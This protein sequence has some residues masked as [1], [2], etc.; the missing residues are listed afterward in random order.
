MTFPHRASL[1]AALLALALVGSLLPAASAREV[2]VATFNILQGTG[3]VGSEAYNAT[4]DVLLRIDADVVCFQELYF[5]SIAPWTNMAAELGYPYTAMGGNNPLA[6]SLSLGF[7]SRF[8]FLATNHVASPPGAVELTRFPFRAVVDVPD[9]LH[10]L[11]LWTSHHKSGAAN[12]DKFRRS[13]E[14]LRISQDIAAYLAD[15]PDHLELV[16]TGDMNDDIRDAQSPAAY[17]SQPSGAPGYYVLGPDVS[18]PVPYA[19]FPSDRYADAGLSRVSAF[20]EGTSTPITRP[21]SS[22]QLDYI[23]LSPALM[24]S[25]LGAPQAEVYHSLNDAGGGLPKLGS[26]LPSGTSATASDHLPI[27]VDIQMADFSCVIPTAPFR[28]SGDPGGPFNPSS[29]TFVLTETNAFESAWIVEPDVDWL[30][31]D[32]PSCSLAPFEPLEIAAFLN[33]RADALPPGLHAASIAF[34]N[35]TTGLLETRDVLLTVHDY[36][37][38]SPSNG[39]ASAGLVG[40]P[41]SPS[42]TSYVVTNKSASPIAFSTSASHSWLSISPSSGLLQPGQAATVQVALNANAAALPIGAHSDT[43]VFSNHVTGLTHERPVALSVAGLLCDALDDCSLAW[44]TGGDAPWTFQSAVASDG[45]DAAQSGALAPNQSSWLET[46]VEGPLRIRFDWKTSSRS[47]HFVRFLVDGAQRASLAGETEW[48]REFHDIASGVHTLRWAYATSA[49]A[50]QGSNA[51]WLDQIRFDFLSISPSSSWTAAGLPGGPFLPSSRSYVLTNSGAKSLTWSVSCLADWLDLSPPSGELPPG[52]SSSVVIALNPNAASKP[53]GSYPSQ[54][55]FSNALSG[56]AQLRPVALE[57]T[58]SLCDALDDC[59]LSWSSGGDAPWFNQTNR[60]FDAS[61]AAQAGSL[62]TNQQ[63]WIETTIQGPARVTFQWRVSSLS[64]A[65]LRFLLDGSPRA[66]ISGTP[67]SWA[68]RLVDIPSG[69]H[70]LR[71]VYVTSNLPPSYENT[72]WLD[73]IVVDPLSVSP[74]TDWHASGLPGGPF[75][76]ASRTYTLTNS[77][78]A[79]ASWTAS[80]STNWLSLSP[81]AGSLAP[82]EAASVTAS[83]VSASAALLPLG[84]HPASLVFSNLA[85]GLTSSIPAFLDTRGSLCDSTEACF[86]DWS[87]GGVLPWFPQTSTSFDGV[88]A[89]QSGALSSNQQSWI[90]AL[91][92]GPVQLHFQWR[93]SSRTNTHLLSFLIDGSTRATLS[94]ATDWSAR[95]FEIPPGVHTARWA[96]A[97]SSTAPSNA[98]AAW[99]DQVQLERFA[100]TPTNGWTAYGLP[101]GPFSPPSQ[102][103][104]LTNAGAESLAWSASSNQPWLSLS[105]SSGSLAPGEGAA[106]ELSFNTNAAAFPVGTR[107]AIATFSNLL[108]GTCLQRAVSLVVRDHLVVSPNSSSH[109][110]FV[111]LPSSPGFQTFSLSN[112]GPDEIEW[113]LVGATNWLSPQTSSGALAPGASAQVLVSLNED[114]HSLPTG[115]NT[116][117]FTFSNLTTHLNQYI[118]V[119]LNQQHPLQ[120][121]PASWFAVGPVGGPFSPPAASFTLTNSCP[122]PQRWSLFCDA[123]WLSLDPPE[124]TLPSRSSQSLSASLNALSLD[125]PMGAHSASLLLLNLDNGTTLTQTVHLAVGINVCDAVEACDLAW[126]LGGDA[127]WLVQTNSTHDGVDALAC[128]PI[129]D[130]QEIWIQTTATGPGTL[131]FWWSVSSEPN[132]DF[133]EF[134]IDGALTNRISGTIAWQPLSYSLPA[135]SHTLRWR[136]AKDV[137]DFAG[138]D[139]AWLDQVA[140]SPASSAMGV[141][142]AWYQRFGLAPPPGASY[143]DLDWLPAA[144][145][146]PLWRQYLSGLDPTQPADAF[147][148]LLIH[149]PPGA[150]PRIEWRGGTNGPS[151]PYVIQGATHLPDGPWTPLGSSPR[152]PGLNVWTNPAPADPSRFFRIQAPP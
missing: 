54:L 55:V 89:A 138:A 56:L 79:A 135:G 103:Y 5:S 96:Y 120:L 81:P 132:Y 44:S 28:P 61:D 147:R 29:Q 145:G 76:P 137:S 116:S 30:S 140:W 9:A 124:G 46:T 19:T 101:G 82:G 15:H 36:L 65:S 127:P 71:W 131:S 53:L 136:Y 73:Q 85:S 130:N 51:A 1:T 16:L 45:A 58:G 112:A 128:A 99:I 102:T 83:L 6:D 105:P 66:S 62:S 22:R 13:I 25:P 74:L 41:F 40:G 142:L 32:P 113:A 11:V 91:V 67:T 104:V 152:A 57:T 43:L 95:S 63:S 26:P 48:T 4:R 94:G 134:H 151:S 17:S 108:S 98:N 150:S 7:F 24:S 143:D 64:P 118:W 60:T 2:R 88:D 149:Q 126:S 119:Y 146:E 97:N 125:L 12:L 117:Y 42:S 133:L 123:P 68:R 75:S 50:P 21:S 80:S 90:E 114:S 93:A 20:W 109:S 141:P 23:F 111:G 100:V 122:S 38:V 27:F 3:D 92:V 31:I 121:S 148:I 18:F 33:E 139:A 49:T 129:S 59:L 144:S 72:G 78:L 34:L 14:A 107:S 8:P 86:L 10:P 70:T 39:F 37:D 35:E 47:A 106:V 77:G 115:R 69:A 84:S 110:G 87:S 52:A